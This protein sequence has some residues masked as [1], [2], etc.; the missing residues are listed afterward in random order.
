MGPLTYSP[1]QGD[2]TMQSI[3]FFSDK[4]KI[5]VHTATHAEHLNRS[6]SIA[7]FAGPLRVGLY[8]LEN[9][10][11]LLKRMDGAFIEGPEG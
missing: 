8:E 11:L 1:K 5:A 6:V 9:G 2:R 4:I 10:E 7:E 3:P